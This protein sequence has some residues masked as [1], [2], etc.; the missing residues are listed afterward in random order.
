[1][2]ANRVYEIDLLM[3]AFTQ[4]FTS[5]FIPLNWRHGKHSITQQ[6][7]RQEKVSNGKN[8]IFSWNKDKE[9]KMI[10]F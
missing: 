1:M 10:I 5:A 3:S 6:S 4:A 2:A 9:I 7:F 8:E